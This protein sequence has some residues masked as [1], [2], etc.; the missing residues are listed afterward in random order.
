MR[1]GDVLE[2]SVDDSG[3]DE[4]LEELVESDK[5]DEEKE[6]KAIEYLFEG[7]NLD[8]SEE[9]ESLNYMQND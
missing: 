6:L 7:Y 5:P 9:L 3:L 1:T 2:N 8:I 4:Y